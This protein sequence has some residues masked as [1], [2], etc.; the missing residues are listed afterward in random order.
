MGGSE[1]WGSSQ[2]SLE[3]FH[4]WED[5][6][7]LPVPFALCSG[8]SSCLFFALGPMVTH[9]TAGKLCTGLSSAP[10]TTLS[11]SAKC[12]LLWRGQKVGPLAL[13]FWLGVWPI[14]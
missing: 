12:C 8:G 14:G 11:M 1:S 7:S 2:T 3:S 10:V 6:P 4:L 5:S 13:C 9:S